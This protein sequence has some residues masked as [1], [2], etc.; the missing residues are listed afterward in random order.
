MARKGSRSEV[1]TSERGE[2]N[3]GE[4]RSGHDQGDGREDRHGGGREDRDG[5]ERER[6]VAPDDAPNLVHRA[7]EQFAAVMGRAPEAVSGLV[8]DEEGWR[9]TVEVVELQRIPPS[10]DVL[11]SYDVEL[12]SDGNLAGYQRTRRYVRSQA[13]EL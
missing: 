3:E 10:T 13:D 5:Y 7:K 1:E 11:A 4:S 2:R 8:R 12:D 9:V 6:R